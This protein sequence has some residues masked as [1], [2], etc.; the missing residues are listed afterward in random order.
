MKTITVR[1]VR[2]RWPEAER[3]LARVQAML[4]DKPAVVA[5]TARVMA[6]PP[7]PLD[8]ADA[9]S[10]VDGSALSTLESRAA[11]FGLDVEKLRGGV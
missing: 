11:A 3:S 9:P 10:E 7:S 1:D 8:G 6:P 2:Q 5:P 4:S